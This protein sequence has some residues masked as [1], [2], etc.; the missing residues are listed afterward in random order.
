[1]FFADAGSDFSSV[2][3]IHVGTKPERKTFILHSYALRNS[4]NHFA[5]AM[6]AQCAITEEDKPI[7]LPD[8]A[9]EDFAVYAKFLYTGLIFTKE[10]NFVELTRCLHLY[11]VAKQL[12][13]T[14]FQDAVV[15]AL[16][17]NIIEYRA[18][19][20]QCR[21]TASQILTI[22]TMTVESS[23]LRKFAQNLCLHS[24][25][26]QGFERKR[27]DIFPVVFQLDL[28]TAAAPF[29]TSSAKSTDMQDPLDVSKSCDYHEHTINGTP[30]YRTKHQCMPNK[31]ILVAAD[32]V[33]EPSSA[34]TST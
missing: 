4:S 27:L 19:K 9:I 32:A 28:L 24:K 12:E 20:G 29:I 6:D 5:V 18:L 22:Y 2:V 3:H 17:E 8:I 26:P 34:V 30:C 10:P 15:D 31:S 23:P 7:N 33:V 21:F 1:M 16:I 13:A 11:K 25:G 14:D